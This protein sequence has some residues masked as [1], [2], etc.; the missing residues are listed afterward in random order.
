MAD[1]AAKIAV[2]V[3]VQLD[4]L[5]TGLAS[6]QTQI[7]NS[8]RQME[9]SLRS[10]ATKPAEEM[11]KFAKR[12]NV[13]LLAQ[14]AVSGLNAVR[15]VAAT[16]NGEFEKSQQILESLPGPLGAW[17][18]LV[19]EV[20]SDFSG[21][22]EALERVSQIQKQQA[23]DQK[24]WETRSPV[25]QDVL[26]RE[27][28][29]RAQS[30]I[31]RGQFDDARSTLTADMQRRMQRQRAELEAQGLDRKL[32]ERKIALDIA[33]EEKKII[34]TIAAARRAEDER[35]LQD[36][37][38][39]HERMKEDAELRARLDREDREEAFR[40]SMDRIER[41][42]RARREQLSILNDA[43]ADAQG[44][45]G[46]NFISSIS[47]GLGQFRVGQV[48]GAQ[49]VARAQIKATQ[50]LADIK[51]TNEEMLRLEQERNTLR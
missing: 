8:S 45:T 26:A 27:A 36:A 32:I 49:E 19:R 44:V 46:G 11:E 18:R 24:Q 16:V 29:A 5:R 22:A 25:L 41:E 21:M 51:R 23:A 35:K 3:E 2:A 38:K 37:R 15:A 30:Q 50:I 17:A 4:Q 47:T 34:D 28:Q 14:A 9:S 31:G 39:L 6:A 12:A 7:A 10:I 1:E 42:T 40:Q 43:L 48:G 20:A 33:Q 13:L